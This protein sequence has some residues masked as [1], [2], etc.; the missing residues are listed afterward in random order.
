[1]I[2]AGEL[3]ALSVASI[4]AFV[5]VVGFAFVLGVS[6]APN[7]SAVLISARAVSYRGAMAF[8]FSPISR[9]GCWPARRWQ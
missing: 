6:D 5:V 4:A 9:A 8:S 7:A 1:M 2:A 3:G